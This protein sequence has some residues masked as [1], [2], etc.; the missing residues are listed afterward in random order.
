MTAAASCLCIGG[1][2]EYLKTTPP[3]N[4]MKPQPSRDANYFENE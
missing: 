2:G 1:L 3:Y 4:Q